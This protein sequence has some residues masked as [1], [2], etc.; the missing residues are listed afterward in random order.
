MNWV[1]GGGAWYRKDDEG[2]KGGFVYFVI[3]R[4]PSTRAAFF[5]GGFFPPL[6]FFSF[7]SAVVSLFPQSFS[8][9]KFQ[10][11]MPGSPSGCWADSFL[12]FCSVPSLSNPDLNVHF[13]FSFKAQDRDD[14]GKCH[15]KHLVLQE[16]SQ[17]RW[18]NCGQ[19]RVAQ[20]GFYQ[21]N[22]AL[23]SLAMFAC[24][25]LERPFA[26][27]TT[28]QHILVI[29]SPAV[30]YGPTTRHC[31]RSQPQHEPNH[32]QTRESP[33]P[34]SAPRPNQPHRQHKS[35]ADEYQS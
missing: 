21:P 12:L 22:S 31:G 20:A 33:V 19:E 5:T 27:K 2:G 35:K 34:R 25:E 14:L 15:N 10:A 8:T 6:C 23:F 29:T 3:I 26:N 4:F 13:H 17:A 1:G 11:K 9:P 28:L 18:H 24:D 16:I 32:P 30:V 7:L